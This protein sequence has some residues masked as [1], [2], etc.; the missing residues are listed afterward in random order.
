MRRKFIKKP[1]NCSALLTPDQTRDSIEKGRPFDKASFN[2]IYRTDEDYADGVR[3]ESV[4]VGDVI[5][6]DYSQDQLNIGVV[7]EVLDVAEHHYG[8]GEQD[9][10]IV[11]TVKVLEGDA[12]TSEG[13]IHE[14]RYDEDEWVGHVI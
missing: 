8:L 14:L 5:S 7:V 6:I 12:T 1:V 11:I 13:S 9:Y 4:E 3:A 2:Q 10:E